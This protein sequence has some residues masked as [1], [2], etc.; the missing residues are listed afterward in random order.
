MLFATAFLPCSPRRPHRLAPGPDRE[1]I[2][3]HDTFYVIG[4]F[5]YVVAP[6]TSRPL[7]G[8]ILVPKATGRQ[9]NEK[10]GKVHFW[11][12]FVGHQLRL[13]ADVLPGHG[14]LSRRPLRPDRVRGTAGGVQR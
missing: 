9:L 3:L 7:A 6:G 13:H 10:L 14:R 8:C 2:Y 12:S 5:H 4:H 1:D 11:L